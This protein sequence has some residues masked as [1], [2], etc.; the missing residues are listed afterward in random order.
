MKFSEL[1]QGLHNGTFDKELAELYGNADM[2]IMRQKTRFLEAVKEFSELYPDRNEIEVYSA[3]G[4]TEI[5]GNHTD[6]Q[7]GCVLAAAVDLDVIAIAAFHNDGVIR[8][9]S[10]GHSPDKIELND[11]SV[12]AEERGT[13]AAI[14]RG[15]VSKFWDMGVK[16]GGFDAYTISNVPSGSGLSSS[17]AFETLLGTIIDR[18]YNSGKVGAVEIAKIGQYS[19]NIYFGKKSGLM[20]QMAS[21]VGGLVFIDFAH[22]D[23]PKIRKI[24]FGFENTEYV[25]YITNTRGSHAEL[26]DDYASIPLEM[27]KV[28]AFFGETHLRNVSEKDFLAAIPELRSSCSDRAILRAAHFFGENRTAQDEAKALAKNDLEE[29]L[30]LVRRSGESSAKW[31]QNLCSCSS[32][33]EQDISL[34]LWASEQILGNDCAARVHGGGFAGTIQAFVPLRSAKLY[35]N[36]MDRFFGEGS[37]RALKIRQFGGKQMFDI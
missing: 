33:A 8:L 11:L 37:C 15:I 1:E 16:I 27:S 13:S 14:I 4:R 7:C 23:D 22:P 10:K 2:E 26:I 25:L 21:S 30:R 24:P 32:P 35:R 29:F 36:K 19:E 3:P 28:A 6:H 20:D 17:A 5:G 18:Y 9:M 31:L 12:H 34:G